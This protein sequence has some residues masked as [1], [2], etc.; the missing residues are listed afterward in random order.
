MNEEGSVPDEILCPI[1]LMPMV[2][3]V[4][5]TDGH[6]YERKAIESW[7][8]KHQTSPKTNIYLETKSLFPNRTLKGMIVRYN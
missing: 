5:T 7:F 1:T 2:D 6:T 4:I 3:P 8:E